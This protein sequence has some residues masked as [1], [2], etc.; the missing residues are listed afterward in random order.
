MRKGQ[1]KREIPDS[2]GARIRYLRKRRNLSLYDVEKATGITAGYLQRIESG[3]RKR[4]SYPVV[5]KIA[6]FFSVS[7][8]DLMDV[9]EEERRE[10]DVIELLLTHNYT[11]GN[12]I[13]ANRAMKDGLVDLMQTM[14]SSDLDGD[15]KLR[16]SIVIIEKVRE[17]LELIRE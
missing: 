13:R 14:M 8:S 3:Q 6:E 4:P 5:E 1:D 9:T 12:G 15:N 17:F 7:V 11:F 10:K 16:D 2:V